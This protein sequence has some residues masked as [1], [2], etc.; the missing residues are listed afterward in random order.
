MAGSERLRRHFLPAAA[1]AH[2]CSH[3]QM[4][5]VIP[6]GRCGCAKIMLAYTV[7]MVELK[8]SLMPLSLHTALN[9]IVALQ[10]RPRMVAGS[11]YH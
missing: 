7:P 11:V 1:N 6:L 3:G 9:A 5:P 2:R 8:A 10:L 4:R